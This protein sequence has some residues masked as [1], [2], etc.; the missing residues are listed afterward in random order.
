MGRSLLVSIGAGLLLAACAGA[1]A[2]LMSSKDAA[3]PS[4]APAPAPEPAEQSRGLTVRLAADGAQTKPTVPTGPMVIRTGQVSIR[5]D[6]LETAI[7]LVTE[8]AGRAG[9]FLANTSIQSGENQQRSATLELKL[10]ADR[11]AGALDQLRTVGKILSA[12]TNAQDVGE[13]F[14][15]VKARVANARRLEERLLNLLATRTGK[16][17]DVLGVERELA[18]VREEIE[19]YEGRIRWLESQVA[20]STLAISLSE[21]APIVGNPGSNPIA[22]AFRE[23]WRNLV[24]ATA[25]IIAIGGALVPVFVMIGVAALLYRRHRR[26]EATA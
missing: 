24:N 8:L 1:P 2:K 16:L 25:A 4:T 5:V 22:E 23:S 26:R 12:T 14:V 13:E 10:P 21:P 19:R 17:D 7:R 6:S 11:Y 20:M 9:G 18:R 3:P 15:D